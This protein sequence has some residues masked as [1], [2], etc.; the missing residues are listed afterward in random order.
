MSNLTHR[1]L[2]K[3]VSLIGATFP[4]DT[5]SRKGKM[6]FINSS[7]HKADIA[8]EQ[9][10]RDNDDAGLLLPGGAGG[11]SQGELLPGG[12]GGQTKVSFCRVD[13]GGQSKVMGRTTRRAED[14][15]AMRRRKF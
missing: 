11:A 8:L 13:P 10:E 14:L 15:M 6:L 9:V 2:D 12:S 3:V 1:D 4:T 7:L 5:T